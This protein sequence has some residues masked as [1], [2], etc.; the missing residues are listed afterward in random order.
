VK[1]VAGAALN[2]GARVEMRADGLYAYNSSNNPTFSLTASTGAAAFTGSITGSDIS[3]SV[4]SF[5]TLYANQLNIANIFGAY[6]DRIEMA[7]PLTTTNNITG[8]SSLWTGQMTLQAGMRLQPAGSGHPLVYNV[9]IN[10]GMM[11]YN[12]GVYSTEYTGTV[13]TP[14]YGSNFIG[15]SDVTNKSNLVEVESALSQ[16][17]GLVVYDYDTPH[18]APKGV[19]S[20]KSGKARQ[21]GITA[22]ALQGVAPH[23]VHD[24]DAPDGNTSFGLGVDI[25]G[26]LATAIAAIQELSAEVASLKKGK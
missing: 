16:I 7:M 19:K 4:G 20:K 24:G 17:E 3:S 11:L 6:T 9:N 5:T 13:G 14:F 21:R 25:Y 26:L 15:W 18:G 1:I 22:Q 10:R 8:T 2:T 23:L 12:D